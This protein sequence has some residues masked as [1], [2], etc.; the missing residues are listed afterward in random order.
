MSRQYLNSKRY[1]FIVASLF[2]LL[3][4]NL[5]FA[6]GLFADGSSE[7]TCNSTPSSQFLVAS[8]GGSNTC[9]LSISGPD[10]G[11]KSGSY[12]YSIAHANGDIRW[13]VEG[14]GVSI[15]ASG[16]VSLSSSA[17][18]AFSVSA[19]DS[20]GTVSKDVRVTDAGQWVEVS[21][22]SCNNCAYPPFSISDCYSGRTRYGEVH[23]I[24]AYG[25][26]QDCAERTA[27]KCTPLCGSLCHPGGNACY[28]RADGA[29]LFDCIWISVTYEWKC[30]TQKEVVKVCAGG[31][32]DKDKDGHYAKSESCSQGDDWDDNDATSYPDAPELYDGKDNDGDGLIDE[33][34][35]LDS[36]GDGYASDVDCNDYDN[37]I[38]PGAPE[39]CDN[40]DNDC[41]GET[42]EGCCE[43]EVKVSPSEVAPQKTFGNTQA[44]IILTLKKPAPSDGCTVKL[45]VEPVDNSGGH[46]HDGNRPTGGLSADSV[47]VTNI[48]PVKHVKYT[49]GEVSGT[50]KI[51]A[52]LVGGSKEEFSIDVKVQGLAGLGGGYYQL[53]PTP[54]GY[55]HVDFYNVQSW[56][57]GLF[58][59]I[60][61]LYHKRFPSAPLLVV[62]DASLE[63][64]GL[65]DYKNT[66]TSPHNTHR[67]GTDID[68]RSKNIPIGINR[69]AFKR[70]VCRA[71]GF[72]YLEYLGQDN[73]H[74]H[75][76]FYEYK[77]YDY[78]CPREEK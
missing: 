71:A 25:S 14:A 7:N 65:Y 19:T 27:G 23:S 10:G 26:M 73:E 18:G 44:D 72:P 60:A 38:Y 43:M 51:I 74:Y 2:L 33:G 69:N 31:C 55:G 29:I 4:P 5:L 56:V 37:T 28:M 62:T 21:S 35:Y 57:K 15:D 42:D 59:S 63:W 68:V 36:D 54:I 17:C 75:L 50:E 40:K 32:E 8:G 20:C 76:F 12:Q 46:L 47:T 39:L 24:W 78:F 77:N 53:K 6:E 11:T 48:E 66:W 22:C 61:E 34:L 9:S 70:F 67:I 64:G 52:E 58:D 3:A 16:V 30:S 13:C 49:S 45:S 41:D 1:L